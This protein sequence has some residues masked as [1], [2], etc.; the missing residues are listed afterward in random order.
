MMDSFKMINR[1][2]N[3]QQPDARLH[4][5]ISFIKSTIRI[6]GY[7]LIPFNIIAASAVLVFSELLGIVEE[8]V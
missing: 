2:N 3:M 8:L 1:E 5:Q 6:I 4:Q 7:C